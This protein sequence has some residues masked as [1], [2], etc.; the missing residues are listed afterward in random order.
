MPRKRYVMT[1][2]VALALAI[3]GST[4][5]FAVADGEPAAEGQF[6]FAVKLRMTNIPNPDVRRATAAAAAP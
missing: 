6:P 5:A 4:V 3:A 1:G 2:A